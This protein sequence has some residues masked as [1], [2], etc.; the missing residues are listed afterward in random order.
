[1]FTNVPRRGPNEILDFCRRVRCDFRSVR[2]AA[3]MLI[4]V[5]F[6]GLAFVLANDFR[7]Q[8]ATQLL[9]KDGHF[10]PSEAVPIASG[11]K[12]H[13]GEPFVVRRIDV[14]LETDFLADAFHHEVLIGNVARDTRDTLGAADP[15]E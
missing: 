11:I 9:A 4:G 2:S 1:M 14:H 8:G 15:N 6:P 13:L 12:I 7:R 3:V 5:P 10:L